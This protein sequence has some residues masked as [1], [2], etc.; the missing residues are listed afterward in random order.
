M[1]NFTKLGRNTFRSHF[2]PKSKNKTNNT[3]IDKNLITK[4]ILLH[5]MKNSIMEFTL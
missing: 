4:T 3:E 1:V 2:T 5:V